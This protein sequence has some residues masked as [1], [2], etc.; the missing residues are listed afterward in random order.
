MVASSACRVRSALQAFFFSGLLLSLAACNQAKEGVITGT[1]K[2]AGAPLPSGTVYFVDSDGKAW[3]SGI[4]ANGLYRIEKV[5][6]GLAKIK[7]VSHLRGPTTSA[8]AR[9]P[10]APKNPRK[11]TLAVQIPQKYNDA[12]TSGLTYDVQ[13]GQQTYDIELTK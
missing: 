2:F 5:P 7:V 12:K 10:D 13:Y 8:N 6:V 1:V 9:G 4:G 11:E 3:H